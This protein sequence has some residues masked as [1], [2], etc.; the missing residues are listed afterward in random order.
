MAFPPPPPAPASY[1][2]LPRTAHR[3]GSSAAVALSLLA[4]LLIA[5][6]VLFVLPSWLLVEGRAARSGSLTLS[7]GVLLSVLYAGLVALI[8][9]TTVRRLVAALVALSVIPIHLALTVVV[10]VT[11]FHHVQDIVAVTTS[12]GV[13]SSLLCL[14]AWGIARRDGALWTIGLVA[15]PIATVVQWLARDDLSD[16]LHELG[17][18][19]R[20]RGPL[21]AWTI[22]WLWNTAQVL[23]TGALCFAIDRLTSPNTTTARHPR[24]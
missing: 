11:A 20:A 8:G 5:D 17:G 12:V 2:A 9:R 21:V 19:G 6:L 1:P 16:L 22:L 15:L 10:R 18:G 4:L 7:L 24:G 14:V 3:P 13:V 23:A